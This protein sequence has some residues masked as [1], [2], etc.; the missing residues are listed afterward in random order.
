LNALA[1]NKNSKPVE[2]EW[3]YDGLKLGS[4]ADGNNSSWDSGPDEEIILDK[5]KKQLHGKTIVTKVNL[6]TG[7]E[8]T[9][10]EVGNTN[11][12]EIT[13]G[14]YIPGDIANTETEI[15]LLEL[16]PKIINDRGD[17]GPGIVQLTQ[18]LDQCMPGPDKNWENRLKDEES[19]VGK[20]LLMENNVDSDELKAKA[21]ADALRELKFAAS[22]FKDWLTTKIINELPGSI[23][24]LDAIKS[25]D[26]FPQQTKEAIDRRSAK[27]QTLARLKAIAGDEKSIQKTGL[28]AISSQPI[29]GSNEEKTLV[30]L[31]KQYN[32]LVA[33]I[34]SSAS[35]EE[36]R[37]ELDFLKDRSSNI[38][39]LITQCKTEVE[40]A[41]WQITK[42]EKGILEN[43]NDDTYGAPVARR[44]ER[45]QNGTTE[46]EKF[47]SI[48][49]V[50]GYSHGEIIRE[51]SSNR[52][53]DFT[54]RNENN[55][56]GD[57]GYQDI[58]IV[59]A[60]NVYG[61]ITCTG[62]CSWLGGSG[63]DKRVSI[64][65]DCNTIFKSNIIDYTHAGDPAN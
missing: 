42:E 62:T 21:A 40:S 14:T 9:T 44:I 18:T 45:E 30:L 51:D 2:D 17:T 57:E 38:K 54:F 55:K 23:L 3:S 46:T 12:K 29:S 47:C 56:L 19:R 26:D 11:T 33:S 63:T 15:I 35:V 64:K 49:I 39:N 16:I 28:A 13:K 53:K 61:D 52:G 1:S 22:S 6:E 37:A 60:K 48:P 24:Y 43:T 7:E 10:E 25:I 4:P 5:F 50:S 59:N 36:T 31:K 34:S 41:G 20:S 65:I 8:K 58:P 32:T 27:L